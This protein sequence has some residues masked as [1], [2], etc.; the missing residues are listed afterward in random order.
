MSYV[1]MTDSNSEFPL[2]IAKDRQLK[3]VPMPYMIDDQEFFYDLGENTDF[4]AFFDKMRAGA[5]PKTSTYST[6]FYLEFFRP[7]LQAGNDI[8]FIAFS[9][10]LSAAFGYLS[11]AVEQLK[12][13]FPQRILRVVDTLSISMGSGLLSYYAFQLYDQGKSLDEVAT[14]VE[15]NRLRINHLFMVDDLVY[16]KRG[17]RISSASALVG[18]V[19]D[20]KPILTVNNEGR[21]VPAEK[22]KGRKK[23]IR[24]LTERACE[25]AKDPQEQM[26][27]IL[28]ADCENEALALKEN[29][30]SRTPYKSVYINSV[31]PVI[32]THCGPGTLA[33]IFLG[34]KRLL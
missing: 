21:I 3:Y 26:L 11:Q 8:L 16:L 27:V 31:G 10:T 4:K 1:I 5:V 33:V 34:S 28:H 14:W 13:E 6:E 2:Q 22:V 25:D 29:I 30:L 9:S 24:V 23:G 17:G 20:V 32:G 12:E 19:L 15:D 18:K 7:T